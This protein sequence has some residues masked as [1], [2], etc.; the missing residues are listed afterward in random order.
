[1][2]FTKA[3]LS[4]C[5]IQLL[6]LGCTQAEMQTY[7]SITSNLS[8]GRAWLVALATLSVT[9]CSTGT[10]EET[11]QLNT[12]RVSQGFKVE[13]VAG[14]ELVD[15]PMFATLDETGRLFVFESKGNVYE[16]SEQAVEH[17]QF[18]IKL[19]ED[20]DGDGKYDKSTVFAD[21]LSFPQGGVFVNGS[22]IASSA[23]DLLKL[24]DTDGD[25]VADERE[26]LLSG[27]ILNVN[28]NSLIG[29][30]QGPDGW[31]YFTSAIMG[32]DVVSQEGEQM[33]GETARIWKVRPDGSDLEWVAAG[34]MNNP[35][36]LAFTRAGAVIG[37]QTFFVDPQRGLRDAITYWI[38]G[39]VY[40]KMN[41]NITRDSLPLTG[42][43]MPVVTQYSRAA[44]SGIGIYRSS[45][46]GEDYKD[47]YFSAQFNTH[48]VIRHQL[49]RK[50]ATFQTDDQVFMWSDSED[51]YPTDV[52]EDADG[53]LLVVETGGWFIKGCPLSQVS[54]PQLKGGIYR[55]R[56]AN[57]PRLKD[58]YGNAIDWAGIGLAG[59][60]NYLEDPRPFVSD[61][62]QSELIAKGNAAI[63]VFI[64]VLKNSVSVDARTKAVYGLYRINT[65]ESWEAVKKG[66]VD[67]HMDVRVA[68][69]K[70]AGLTEDNRF[71]DL[72][73]GML[74]DD[75]GP[76]R[77]QAATALGQIGEVSAVPGLLKAAENASD[78]FENH[79]IIYALISIDEPEE[80]L[81]ALN[82]T[83]DPVL[84]IALIALDQM[85][86][87]K[88]TATQVTPYFDHPSLRKTALWVAS[89]HP[90]WSDDMISYLR[91]KLHDQTSSEDVTTFGDII[92]NYCGAEK[93][94]QFLNELLSS[95][96]RDI[97]FFA[98]ESMKHCQVDPFPLIWGD[99]VGILLSN[100]SD[101][102]L[103]LG[104]VELIKLRG[105]SSLKSQLDKIV[106]DQNNPISLRIAALDALLPEQQ[107]LTAPQYSLLSKQLM[108]KSSPV[109][110]QQAASAI[111]AAKLSE[112]QL[113]DLA[114]Q[115]LPDI[116]PFVLP[117]LL[118][119]FEGVD[120]IHVGSKLATHLL[121]LPS[122]DNLT[123]DYVNELFANYPPEIDSYLNDLLLR[124]RM[125]RQ[126]RLTH[127]LK[128]ER[129]IN[130]GSEQRGRE[131]YFGKAICF[132]CHTM[133]EKGGALGPDLTAIQKDRSI[134]DII[135][136]I[137]Y[138]SVSFVREYETYKITTVNGE[139]RGII[140]KKTQEMI[141]LETA[142]E[143]SFR[144]PTKEITTIEPSNISM[145]PQGL[146]QLLT[147]QEFSDLMAYILGKELEY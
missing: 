118:P 97:K 66:F 13:L 6:F 59:L 138:P 67:D 136:A 53:S 21:H 90:E 22:L 129:S 87:G 98:M 34:G 16:T 18:R 38:E 131:L 122:L 110:S 11:N 109:L 5:I 33:K 12:I 107:T 96:S 117:R 1:M 74:S 42:D 113:L 40:G 85:P 145:M 91:R 46:F 45:L 115:V 78:R 71:V 147:E 26:V 86:S 123:E 140:Q 15:Y 135:E 36:E 133:Q 8:I 3:G 35:V 64:D 24:T 4:S 141:L 89:H 120:N 137:V 112:E 63:G 60:A 114:N 17:P 48:Q 2:E 77:R 54:K 104:A 116:D 65:N 103:N 80:I 95:G 111:T 52:L 75:D 44:P 105:I 92:T 27:W 23:P 43:L 126:E 50:G 72:L 108:E 9:G 73:T 47:N 142:P 121:G 41:S 7:I 39:G 31:L 132:T 19:L 37:T 143:T 84:E 130:L 32:F 14:P 20:K 56:R 124:L 55:I 144:I 28:A 102:G 70:I 94:Q 58:P 79:A 128:I 76:V 69:A 101:P 61:R 100:S 139:F 51:F 125:V 10:T 25:G 119:V 88:L 82:S 57:T 30:F 83:S 134:H 81:A 93:M 99:Q 127:I 29:P 146:D 62:A 106:G 68:T 49:S